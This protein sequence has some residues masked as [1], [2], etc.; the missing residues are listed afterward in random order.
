MQILPLVCPAL[1][2]EDGE[3]R[4]QALRCMQDCLR[5]L[6]DVSQQMNT[7]A[8]AAKGAEENSSTA[9]G[10]KE[11]A[12]KKEGFLMICFKI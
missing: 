11:W 2:D 12:F 4:K 7:A 5:R 8:V 6:E 9:G 3:V 10:W 1:M